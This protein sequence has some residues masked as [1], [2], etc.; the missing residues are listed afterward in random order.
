MHVQKANLATRYSWL[1]Q[2]GQPAVDANRLRNAVT[3]WA[4]WLRRRPV[5]VVAA[6]SELSFSSHDVAVSRLSFANSAPFQQVTRRHVDRSEQHL[7][8]ST[9]SGR[10]R[11]RVIDD[12]KDQLTR[13]PIIDWCAL[14]RHR[15]RPHLRLLN[16]THDRL[17]D[18][19]EQARQ[20]RL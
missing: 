11:H 6:A 19:K 17:A 5:W 7:G 3:C 15:C 18:S 2:P 8:D 12:V 20:R 4:K 14:L 9:D 13:Q 1:A 16:H 10:R